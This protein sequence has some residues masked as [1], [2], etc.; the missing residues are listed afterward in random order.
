MSICLIFTNI[1]GAL[2]VKGRTETTMGS[3]A[4]ALFPITAVLNLHFSLSTP[5]LQQLMH[6]PTH[7]A[8]VDLSQPPP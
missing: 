7:R 1:L 4:L 2:M 3:L 8:G 6:F 5:N